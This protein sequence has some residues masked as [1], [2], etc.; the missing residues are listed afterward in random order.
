MKKIKPV[1]DGSIN[2][3]ELKIAHQII[4]N[5]SNIKSNLKYIVK[6]HVDAHNIAGN[7]KHIDANR[8]EMAVCLV[9]DGKDK[10]VPLIK[11]PAVKVGL[12]AIELHSRLKKA[13]FRILHVF[14]GDITLSKDGV[15]WNISNGYVDGMY[16][17]TV[18][19]GNDVVF[20]EKGKSEAFAL[21][22]AILRLVE[23]Q[24]R[25]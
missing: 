24:C 23:E 22:T 14:M 10:P 9:L 4:S 6:D 13:G 11:E 15:Y 2:S 7:G 16:E 19:K 25:K 20:K 1:N 8:I 18:D 12:D 3:Y 5:Y 21:E 17:C